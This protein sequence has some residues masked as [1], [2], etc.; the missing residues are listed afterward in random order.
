MNKQETNIKKNVKHIATLSNKSDHE[1]RI[2]KP[3]VNR[4]TSRNGVIQV[5]PC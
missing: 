4:V 5:Q 2:L 1:I 3:S